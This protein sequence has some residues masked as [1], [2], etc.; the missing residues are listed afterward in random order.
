MTLKKYIKYLLLTVLMAGAGIISISVP[1]YADIEDLTVNTGCSELPSY[2][3]ILEL[4]EKKYDVFARLAKRGESAKVQSFAQSESGAYGD[5]V[6]I[7]QVTASGDR[8]T[9]VGEFTAS[10]ESYT[11]QL[12]STILSRLPDA[13]RPSIML[14]PHDK[15]ICK[16][17]TECT[18][19]VAGQPGFVRPTGTLLN[20]DS[21]RVVEVVDPALD[22]AKQVRYYTDGTLAYTSNH[23]EEFD[24]RYI[25][26]GDQPLTRVIVYDSGQQIVLES[27]APITYTDNFGN[28]LFRLTQKYPDTLTILIWLVCIILGLAII[29]LVL[30][31]LRKRHDWRVHHG[32]EVE[33][34]LNI[35]Q[36]IYYAVQ[37]QKGVKIARLV[38]GSIAT[39]CVIMLVIIFTNTYVAQI[40]SIDGHSMEKTYFTGNQ[41]LLNK[42]P[43]TLASLN[44]TE[45]VPKRGEVVIVNS[46][47]G[48]AVLSTDDVTGLTLIKRVI[49]LPGERVVIKDGILTVYNQEYPKGFQPDDGSSWQKAMTPDEKTENI[50]IQLARSEIFVSGDNRPASIDSRFNGPISTKE[51]LGVVG[52]KVWPL[53]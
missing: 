27:K 24:S 40:I 11:L 41:V 22:T 18:L 14:L 53:W 21:L 49:A 31:M 50:D 39:L 4:T 38:I 25:E 42:I 33:K 28:F 29:L 45:Y 48:N 17:T 12:A 23:L 36:R 2:T 9:K 47:F 46:S 44:N 8:W 20:Q 10:N 5:C 15:P 1:A 7:G 51:V 3:G 13:N 19:T 34:A 30:R 37:S 35:F 6:K 26:Y 32:L 52:A 43:K 16:P